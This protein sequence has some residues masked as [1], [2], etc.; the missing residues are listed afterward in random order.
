VTPIEKLEVPSSV[1]ALLASRIDRLVERD[2]QLL[3]T[4]AVIGRT[5]DEPILEAVAELPRT[6]LGEALAALETAELVTQQA[7]Y[8]VAEYAFKHQLT[9]EVALRSQLQERRRQIHAAVARAIEQAN[10]GKL[11]EK[12]ALLAH[13]CE[14]AGDALAA[15]GWHR[16][17]AE[18][19]DLRNPAEALRHLRRC[20]ELISEFPKS[21]EVD[22][23][24]LASSSGILRGGLLGLSV[25][26]QEVDAA[27]REGRSLAEERGDLP[28]LAA[29][30]IHYQG[31]LRT[32][33][34]NQEA[35]AALDEAVRVADRTGDRGLRAAARTV[36]MAL[37]M[38]GRLEDVLARSEEGLRLVEGDPHLGS[39]H[40]G[41]SPLVALTLVGGWA[42]CS[43]G[44]LREG[45]EAVDRGLE[46]ARQHDPNSFWYGMGLM[47]RILF[48]FLAGRIDRVMRDVQE[49]AADADDSSSL[50]E[51]RYSPFSLGLA[52][53]AHGEW[54]EAIRNLE[55]MRGGLLQADH[56]L[57]EAYLGSGDPD[58]ARALAEQA[59]AR[60]RERGAPFFELTALSSLARVLRTIDAAGEVQ[61]IE[62]ILSRA[63]DLVRQ[64]GS[65]TQL[66][67]LCEE[68]GRL[69]QQL[70]SAEEADRRLR[71]A[72]RLF[73]EIGATGHAERLARE[74][75][76]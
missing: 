9:Q 58:R 52:H 24:R 23:L 76:S 45:L 29:I 2:K 31:S 59:L 21:P 61:R 62:A 3:Q 71:E 53:L 5:F 63:E 11:D 69:A 27:Y 10:P 13:H 64:T 30:L 50:V 65:R 35:L 17:T 33:G 47:V 22:D 8:P 7:L 55:A 51:Q 42:H 36:F 34:R 68:R 74:L 37:L 16:C 28:A 46:L 18:W 66:P 56:W 41:Y 25:G 54:Q 57:A 39:E 32:L 12:A 40:V 14:E 67:F 43:L 6:E 15:A 1:H 49:L 20:A 72:H 44:R 75:D 4:A 70:G 48:S 60:H 73:T 38:A 19:L 26:N